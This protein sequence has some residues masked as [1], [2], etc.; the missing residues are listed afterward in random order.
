MVL[1]SLGGLAGSKELNDVEEGKTASDMGQRAKEA[2]AAARVLMME[3]AKNNVG[4]IVTNHTYEQQNM[5]GAPTIKFGGG[6][7]FVYACSGLII[8]QKKVV[9]EVE[10]KDSEGRV[11]TN[12]LGS[13]VVITSEKNRMVPAGTRGYMYIDFK[14]G[15]NKYYGLLDDAIEHGFIE[16]AGAWYTLKD[17]DGNVI[18]KFQKADMYKADIWDPILKDLDEKVQKKMAYSRHGEEIEDDD[19]NRNEEN[20]EEDDTMDS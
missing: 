17:K 6:E 12:R 1:D 3:C 8:V 13:I 10:G 9:K 16:Q 18:K 11:I 20:P 4:M 5:M 15:L 2:R 7:G 19:I 14:K